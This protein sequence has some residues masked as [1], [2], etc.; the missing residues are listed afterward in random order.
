MLN[1][2]LIYLDLG[3]GQ[4]RDFRIIRK[5][6]QYFTIISKKKITAHL[7]YHASTFTPMSFTTFKNHKYSQICF[8]QISF[9]NLESGFSLVFMG[10]LVGK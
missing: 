3:L 1:I 4:N 10:K 7:V 6:G 9:L 5:T 8:I 2:R